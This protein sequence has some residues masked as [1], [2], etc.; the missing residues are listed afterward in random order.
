M[1]RSVFS[2]LR[3]NL[4]TKTNMVR[5]FTLLFT[6]FLLSIP[7]SVTF[8]E[9]VSVAVDQGADYESKRE[10]LLDEQESLLNS[11]KKRLSQSKTEFHELNSAISNK[12][13]DV[14][15]FTHKVLTLEDQLLNIDDQIKNTNEKLYNIARQ[16]GEKENEI[17]ELLDEQA[18]LT[19]QIEDTASLL[20]EYLLLLYIHES[21]FYDVRTNSSNLIKLL[22][23]DDSLTEN[24]EQTYFL[25]IMEE[26]LGE[27]ITLLSSMEENLALQKSNLE[28]KRQHLNMIQVAYGDHVANLTALE[29]GKKRLLVETKNKQELYARLIEDERAQQEQIANEISLLSLNIHAF[30]SAIELIRTAN[31]PQALEKAIAIRDEILSMRK[32]TIDPSILDGLTAKLSWPLSPFRGLTAYFDDSGYRARFGV[33][34]HAIDIRAPHGS[35]LFASE[36]GIVMKA[37]GKGSDDIGYHYIAIMHAGGIQTLYGH[38]SEIL[39]HE[40]QFVR[41]GDI[42]GLSGATPGTTGAGLRTTG[43]HL[44]FEVHSAGKRT[45][46]LDYL[47][48][49]VLPSQ[50][51][52]SGKIQELVESISN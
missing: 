15:D 36:D 8:G 4:Y 25:K 23:D 37:Y 1:N 33:N 22:L 21:T 27:I 5:F 9:D 51:I 7:L 39:V 45:D 6:I 34:H 32:R 30:D 19:L 11:L 48:L 35:P 3:C 49:D 31:D 44:H 12:E 24:F 26:Q 2:Y 38:V 17:T 16:I 42:I 43:P 41:K 20:D 13:Y 52:P 50:Y 14:D 29:S 47:P 28:V 10:Q 18:I 40:G 46:P